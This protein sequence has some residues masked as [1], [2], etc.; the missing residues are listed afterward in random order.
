MI[1]S[2]CGK[3]CE[4]TEMELSRRDI[5]RLEKIGYC[6]KDF[7]FL[8]DG[9]AH[10]KNIEGVCYFFNPAE[11]KCIVYK[12][13]PLGCY[14][15]PVV[16]VVNKDVTVD[17]FCSMAQTVSELELKR[18]GKILKKLLKTIDVER[19]QNLI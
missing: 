17:E 9:V 4:N 10:L 1:C 6:R 11:K 13:R 14:V 19:T 3:C 16:Y 5:E 15:Y 2:R 18:K 7:S 12:D 8:D